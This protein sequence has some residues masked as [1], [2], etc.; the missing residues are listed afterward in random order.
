MAFT[1]DDFRSLS[2]QVLE[3]WESGLDRDWSAQAGTVEWTCLATAAHVIDCVWSYALFLTSGRQDRYPKGIDELHATP[4]ATPEDMVDHLRA[5]T[6]MLWSVIVTADPSAEAIIWQSPQPATGTPEQF[7]A[8]GGLELA[9]HAY[10]VCEGLGVAFRPP[11]DLCRRLWANTPM[12]I[13]QGTDPPTEDAWADLLER[14]G[15]PRP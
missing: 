15:R 8:R 3:A 2:D 4:D 9:L 1:A 10:D 12:W 6:T 13:H 7:A 5:V 14:S 11:D